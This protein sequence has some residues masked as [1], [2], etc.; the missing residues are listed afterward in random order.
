MLSQAILY[1]IGLLTI[2]CLYIICR[3]TLHIKKESLV[4]TH[5][6][7]EDSKPE[8]VISGEKRWFLFKKKRWFLKKKMILEKGDL[9]KGDFNQPQSKTIKI[10]GNTSKNWHFYVFMT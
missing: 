1:F 3:F 4:T 10:I 9:G 5:S 8:K 2:H 7:K 6:T